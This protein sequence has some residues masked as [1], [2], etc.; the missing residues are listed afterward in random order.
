MNFLYTLTGPNLFWLLLVGQAVASLTNIFEWT[1]PSLIASVWFPPSE[2][3]TSSAL[4]GAITP[5]VQLRNYPCIPS[6]MH[7]MC[8]ELYP[9]LNLSSL[10]S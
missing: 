1:V 2:R 5:N 6:H 9:E 8:I 7:L 3:A 10:V 4:V